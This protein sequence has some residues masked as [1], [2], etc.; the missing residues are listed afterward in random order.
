[1]RHRQGFILLFGTRPIIS[2]DSRAGAVETICPRCNRPARITGKT[3]RQWFTVFFI[4]IFPISRTQSFSECPLCG[5]QFPVPVSELASQVATADKEQSQRA[6]AMYNSLRNSPANSV[7]L[8]ELMTLYATLGE[9]DQAISAA[10]EFPQA[11]NNSEQCMTT[12]G[13]VYLAKNQHADAIQWLDAAIERN[14]ALGEAQYFR[15][16]AHLT[17]TPADPDRAIAAARGARAA[18]YPGSDDLLREAEKRASA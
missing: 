4:P 2:K 5:G 1:M 10:G 15:A 3:Y 14:P 6:I 13:R 8:N 11:L 12:L 17:K 9:Y 18:G 16:I 7:T